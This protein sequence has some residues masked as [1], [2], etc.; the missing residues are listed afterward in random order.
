MELDI[1]QLFTLAGA[2]TIEKRFQFA[3]REDILKDVFDDLTLRGFGTVL[4]G[5]RGVG[6]TSLGWQIFA[7]LSGDRSL[8]NERGISISPNAKTTFKCVWLTCTNFI[9]TISDLT[10]ALLTEVDSHSLSSVY[11]GFFDNRAEI[12]RVSHSHRWQL[13]GRQV[14]EDPQRDLGGGPQPSNVELAA[15]LTLKEL[16]ARARGNEAN[17]AELVIFLDEFDQVQE[18]TRVGVLIKA[19]NNVRFVVLGVSSNRESLIGQHPSIGRKISSYEVPLFRQE[20]VEWFFDSI[21]RASE[22]RLKFD[23]QFRMLI[24]E[25]SSGFPWLVQQLGYYS[26]ANALGKGTRSQAPATVGVE[27]YTEIIG[28]FLRAQLGGDNLNFN[29]LSEVAKKILI[30][31]SG[32]ERGRRLEEEIISCLQTSHRPFY[33]RGVEDLI[34][35]QLVYSID[36]EVRI[37]DPLT[38]VLVSIAVTEGRIR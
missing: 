30:V 17:G 26:A 14:R 28:S 16:L 27:S 9:Q 2:V 8:F 37:R 6:K 11:P 7:G 19:L 34:D 29:A 35:A 1:E 15:F 21:E 31:L 22:G 4:Y 36:N 32:S 33:D 23:A 18:N 5:E 38:K 25:R 24:G 12:A 20:N 3:G 10:L 13:E